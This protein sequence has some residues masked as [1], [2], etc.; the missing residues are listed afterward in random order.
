MGRARRLAASRRVRIG[1]NAVFMTGALAA[2]V[3]TVLHFIHSG[4]PLA[5][6]DPL[7]VARRDVT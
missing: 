5:N 2:A 7:L 6:A 1:L 4:W 3:L